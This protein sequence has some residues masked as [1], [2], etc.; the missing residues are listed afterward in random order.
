M[1]PPRVNGSAPA[2]KAKGKGRRLKRFDVYECIYGM[3]GPI[4]RGAKLWTVAA[5]STEQAQQFVADVVPQDALLREVAAPEF[6]D[7]LV[8]TKCG[9]GRRVT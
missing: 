7:V 1:T 8:L 2:V 5:E 6:F 9:N 3:P 4:F